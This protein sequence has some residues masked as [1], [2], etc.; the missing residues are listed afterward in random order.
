MDLSRLL[1]ISAGGFFGTFL[2]ASIG[3]IIRQ[4][5]ASPFPLATL[6]INVVGCLLIGFF[7]KFFESA[8]SVWPA[9]VMVGVLG[10]FTTF[11]AFGLETQ[12]LMTD[13]EFGLAAAYVLLSVGLGLGA[14][15]AGMFTAKLF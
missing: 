12:R 2:R 15:Y 7:Y 14:V 9:V 10:G 11:S 5:F 13:Q 8:G 3:Q 6:V 4:H 1:L